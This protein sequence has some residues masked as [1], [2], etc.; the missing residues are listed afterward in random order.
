MDLSLVPKLPPPSSE[1]VKFVYSRPTRYLNTLQS[2]LIAAAIMFYLL[3]ELCHCDHRAH[4]LLWDDC[5]LLL[6]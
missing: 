3:R 5:E 4:H 6:W 1:A 2:V